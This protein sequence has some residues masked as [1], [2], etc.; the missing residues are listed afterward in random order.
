M[1]LHDWT[2]VSPSEFHDMHLNWMAAI[3]TRLN[4]GLLPDGYYALAEQKAEPFV[5]DVLAL[6]S[7]DEGDSVTSWPAGGGGPAAATLVQAEVT[8]SGRRRRPYPPARRVVV[9]H[10]EGQRLVAVIE[11]VSP[12]NKAKTKS[13]REFVEKSAA[14][15]ENGIHLTVVD[16]F[17]NSPRLPQGFGGAVW[18]SVERVKAKY[19][20]QFS[21]THAAFAAKSGGGCLVNFQSSEVGAALPALP[22]YLTPTACVLLP[23]DEAYQ[24][25]WVGYPKPLRQ[26][27]EA[28][29]EQPPAGR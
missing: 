21:R 18:R 15:I 26:V 28:P 11:L 14:L 12:G 8:L 20:P 7:S 6:G 9:R 16:V 10:V 4:T 2:R 22:L 3:R 1:P 5:P 24:D 19:A 13:E 29:A 23:L 27:L 25:A 17:P